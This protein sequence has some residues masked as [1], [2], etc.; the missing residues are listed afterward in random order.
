MQMTGSWSD[1]K[2]DPMVGLLLGVDL[3]LLILLPKLVIYR[4]LERSARLTFDIWAKKCLCW[5]EGHQEQVRSNPMDKFLLC[6]CGSNIT[7]QRCHRIGE[8]PWLVLVGG[9][10]C[11]PYLNVVFT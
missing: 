1:N 11:L 6:A 3:V 9:S 8:W 2:L 5:K 7:C 10:T 4:T